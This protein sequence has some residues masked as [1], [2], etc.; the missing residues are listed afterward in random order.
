LD[1]L[2]HRGVFDLRNYFIKHPEEVVACAK[3]VR[4][5]D[6]N[7]ATTRLF[8]GRAKESVLGSLAKLFVYESYRVFMEELVHLHTKK[9]PFKSEMVTKA[10]GGRVI[11]AIVEVSIAPNYESNWKRVL[12]SVTDITELKKV[13]EE[14]RKRNEDLER[15]SE[16]AVGME[17]ELVELGKGVKKLEA[18]KGA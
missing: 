14:V 18:K 8:G 5:L 9:T 15:L 7:V 1:R 17:T 11:N 3:T 12:V 4:I 6:V 2:R 10:S 13:Q 16:A